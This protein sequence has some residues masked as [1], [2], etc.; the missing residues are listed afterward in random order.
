MFEI[1]NSVAR[2][3]TAIREALS[4]APNLGTL[5]VWDDGYVDR[6]PDYMRTIATNPS[7]KRIRIEPH[8]GQL[9]YRKDLYN[10]MKGDAKLKALVD[11]ADERYSSLHYSTK[12]MS[13]V[14]ISP[15]QFDR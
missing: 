7:L 8:N 13:H 3:W 9:R 10:A 12:C 14:E 4:C 15:T 5:V 1:P 6:V 2:H 11:L